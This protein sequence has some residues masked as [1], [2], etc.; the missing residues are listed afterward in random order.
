VPEFVE[1]ALTSHRLWEAYLSRPA[2]QRNDYIGWI[3]AARQDATRRRRLELMLEELRHGDRYM[4]MS[5]RPRRSPSPSPA[6]P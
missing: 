4:R 2:Y 3:V 5:W 1:N 6:D